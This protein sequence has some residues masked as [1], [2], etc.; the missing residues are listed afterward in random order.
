MKKKTCIIA[1]MAMA[2]AS[3]NAIDVNTI[4]TAGPFSVMEPLVIDSIN[5][6]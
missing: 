1:M 2:F 6:A 4:R 3:A 5:A